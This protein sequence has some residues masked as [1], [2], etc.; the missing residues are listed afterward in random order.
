MLQ[1][2]GV[3]GR[4]WLPGVV[5]A[6]GTAV[7]GWLATTAWYAFE[8][9]GCGSPGAK[10][11]CLGETLLAAGGALVLGPV[12]LGLAYRA[13]GV[14][15]PV[16]SALLA[17]VLAFLLQA[18]PVLV[19]AVADLA[20]ARDATPGRYPPLL[21]AAVLALAALG[22][23]LAWQGPRR[24]LR[25]CAAG[26]A[27][28]LLCVATVA[29]QAPAERA[30]DEARLVAATVPL[31]LPPEQ[32]QPYGPYVADDG[33]LSYDA[34]PVGWAGYGFEGVHVSVSRATGDFSRATGDFGST[35]AFRACADSG[36]VRYEVADPRDAG[37][38]TQA[39]RLVDGHLVTVQTYGD[40]GPALDP[41]AFLGAM[42]TVDRETFLDRR[43]T[44]R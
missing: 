39:W 32:W 43:F 15:R 10:F 4:W 1:H 13:V 19:D 2:G 20:G 44:D 28:V 38:G 34:V 24:A 33:S 41:V 16:L 22:G 14:R 37:S 17:V 3:E 40:G 27:L 7:V 30:R 29:L 18:L 25:A 12:L 21:V 42:T 23:G 36:D 6:A 26:V 8:D 31:L 11:V 9:G 35:C 5:V